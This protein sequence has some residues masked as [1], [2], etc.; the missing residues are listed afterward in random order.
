MLDEFIL[1]VETAG[2][3]VVKPIRVLNAVEFGVPQRRRRVFVLGS[4]QGLT[5]P[6]YP[7]PPYSYDDR[8]RIAAPTVWD[9]IGDLPNIG[10][11]EY[12]LKSE[13]YAGN[14]RAGSPYA[15]ILRGEAREP[16]NC[17]LSR[18]VNGAGL[19]GCLRTTHTAKTIKRFANT[20]QGT[21]DK[22]SRYYRLAKNGFAPTI[23]AGTG[24]EQGSFM[25]ARPIHPFQDRCITVREAARLHSFPDWFVFHPT[26]WHG[27]RQIG[28]SVPPRLARALAESVLRAIDNP[29][30][31]EPA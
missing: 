31:E 23:R 15:R 2:Y 25:A 18:Q 4:R 26:K 13:V 16:E 5:A 19:T 17:L 1:R 29:D 20:K 6:Q 9:A 12:L 3:R 24:P 22:V 21:Y 27:F 14:L 8:G 28:N 11:F 30:P 10:K 7:K